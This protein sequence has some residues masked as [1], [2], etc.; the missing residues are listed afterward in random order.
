MRYIREKYMDE[1]KSGAIKIDWDKKEAQFSPNV[2]LVTK[3]NQAT[4]IQQDLNETIIRFEI[5]SNKIESS[6]CQTYSYPNDNI[7]EIG[8]INK[9]NPWYFDFCGE[10]VIK[11]E[12]KAP[13][14]API[15]KEIQEMISETK[16]MLT[17]PTLE[18]DKDEIV[19]PSS[20]FDSLKQPVSEAPSPMPSLTPQEK[21]SETAPLFQALK[22]STP[23]PILSPKPT[24]PSRS[25]T[26]I[27][28]HPTEL[29]IPPPTV[30]QEL[31]L[32]FEDQ[33]MKLEEQL[34]STRNIVLTLDKRLSAGLFN[35]SEYLEKKNFLIKK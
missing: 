12:E 9:S 20:L 19:K 16:A 33:L 29:K 22:T 28:T 1:K 11:P 6:E 17:I 4:S 21:S 34:T 10:M 30:G 14:R 15:A 27:P 8:T 23:E 26:P 25:T 24:P 35:L 3:K 2:K 13:P 31:P 7:I 5:S 18:V 32:S